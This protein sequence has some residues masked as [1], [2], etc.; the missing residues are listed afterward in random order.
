MGRRGQRQ[1][2]AWCAALGIVIN[3]SECVGAVAEQYDSETENGGEEKWMEQPR[4]LQG[5]NDRGRGRVP[6]S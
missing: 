3:Q 2:R 5:R 6:T 1:Q 4:F